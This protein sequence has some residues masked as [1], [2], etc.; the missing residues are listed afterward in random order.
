LFYN[1]DIIVNNLFALDRCL[2]IFIPLI[3]W[4]IARKKT[5]IVCHNPFLLNFR[6]NQVE[7]FRVI[8]LNHS[9]ER[10]VNRTGW[11]YFLPARFSA[12][13]G[14]GFCPAETHGL[15]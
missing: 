12:Y 5:I 15:K 3:F 9:R 6:N 4:S 11:D 2:R 8:R 7:F 13:F 10:P 14:D 1:P